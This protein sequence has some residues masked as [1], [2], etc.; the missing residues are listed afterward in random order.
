MAALVNALDNHTSQQI[1]EN[2]HVEYGWSNNIKEW[3]PQFYYQLTRTNETTIESLES[4]LRDKLY[5]IINTLRM[6]IDINKQLKEE[7]VHYI[8]LLYK[9]VNI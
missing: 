5:Y 6:N 4:M 7:Y 3:I 1:G 2:R 8:V 9:I